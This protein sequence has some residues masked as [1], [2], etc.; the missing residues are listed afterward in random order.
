MR[1][2]RYCSKL[3]VAVAVAVRRV[4]SLAVRAAVGV[5]R[6]R[7]SPA[8]TAPPATAVGALPLPRAEQAAR[9]VARVS[10]VRQVLL[11]RRG[12][13]GRPHKLL[14]F[15]TFLPVPPPA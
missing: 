7:V 10:M 3:A 12:K 15:I 2:V 8:A 9:A 11:L 14:V 5:M 1:T 4:P 6:R 13:A